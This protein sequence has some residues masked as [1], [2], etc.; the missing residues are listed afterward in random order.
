MKRTV[1]GVTVVVTVASVKSSTATRSRS[2]PAVTPQATAPRQ[3]APSARG[4]PGRATPAAHRAHP[5]GRRSSVDQRLPLAAS[6]TT[7]GDGCSSSSACRSASAPTATSPASLGH[8]AASLRAATA[9][10]VRRGRPPVALA[11]CASSSCRRGAPR[12]ARCARRRRSVAMRLGGG[13]G[14][15]AGGR[16]GARTPGRRARRCRRWCRCSDRGSAPPPRR[17]AGSS[18]VVL[19]AARLFA[20]SCALSGV[21]A[22][23]A[24]RSSSASAIGGAG[25]G[26]LRGF[27]IAP[28]PATG[29]GSTV[30]SIDELVESTAATRPS[31]TRAARSERLIGSESFVARPTGRSISRSTT[32]RRRCPASAG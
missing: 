29:R 25:S 32:R 6:P 11:R 8:G 21:G 16:P 19:V 22:L 26:P 20:A 27:G 1:A 9:A 2:E 17:D 23:G 13:L 28:R 5:T 31:S 24:W 4:A 7:S 15:L 30:A 18:V 10:R 12:R 14:D 3:A